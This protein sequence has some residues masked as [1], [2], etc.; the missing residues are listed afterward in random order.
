MLNKPDV[1]PLTEKQ[2]SLVKSFRDKLAAMVERGNVTQSERTTL[3]WTS[4]L[5][6]ATLFK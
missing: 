5:L 6:M 4:R 3:L 2:Q 1:F